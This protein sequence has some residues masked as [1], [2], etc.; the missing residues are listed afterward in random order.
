MN[1]I[2]NRA[3]AVFRQPP[4]RGIPA[5]VI[6]LFPAFL[7]SC[8]GERSAF[9]DSLKQKRAVFI[10]GV[11]FFP[12]KTLMCGPSAMAGVLNYYGDR[13]TSDEIAEKIFKPSLGGTLAMDM[14]IYARERGYIASYYG[15]GLEDLKKQIRAGAPTIVF[16]N[17]GLK[18]YPVGHYAVVVGYSE[19]AIVA[20]W[21]GEKEKV[22]SYKKFLR[23]WEKTGFSTI[24]VTKK[25]H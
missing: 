13:I 2:F 5:F 23:Y 14:V 17:L 21:G 8:V 3:P 24:A 6:L 9:F 15:G 1:R 11:P 7:L 16:L 20:H 22:L 4:D 19:E 10:E 12:Q 25:K 18:S